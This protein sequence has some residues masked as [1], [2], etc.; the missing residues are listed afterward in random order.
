MLISPLTQFFYYD[1]MSKHLIKD[2]Y[3]SKV[4]EVTMIPLALLG[5]GEKTTVK[6]ITGNEDVKKHLENLGFVVGNEV[7]VLSKCG[8]N[9]IVKIL[10]SRVGISQDLALRIM[11]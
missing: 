4:S 10:E 9:V 6:L 1:K 8:K 7:S 5:E 3:I 2:Y 11:T